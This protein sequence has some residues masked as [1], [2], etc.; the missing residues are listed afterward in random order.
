MIRDFCLVMKARIKKQQW[1]VLSSQHGK[2]CS[3]DPEQR[4]RAKGEGPLP[5]AG[6][7]AG[8]PFH[9][10]QIPSIQVYLNDMEVLDH[11]YKPK[12]A[13]NYY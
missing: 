12:F 13:T 2:N 1:R 7:S 3:Q 4:R 5:E 6:V 8:A 9:Q 10:K 11:E